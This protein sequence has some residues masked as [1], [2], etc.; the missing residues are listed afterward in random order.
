MLTKTTQFKNI[1]I[2]H[3]STVLAEYYTGSEYV[4]LDVKAPKLS[5]TEQGNEQP[6]GQTLQTFSLENL[7]PEIKSFPVVDDSIYKDLDSFKNYWSALPDN[8]V[9]PAL[10]VVSNSMDKFKKTWEIYSWYQGK[11]GQSIKERGGFF[12]SNKDT[13]GDYMFRLFLSKPN[14]NDN[15]AILYMLTNLGLT[16]TFKQKAVTAIKQGKFKKGIG[17]IFR[18]DI[19]TEDKKLLKAL[20]YSTA[21]DW[22]E[23]QSIFKV[24]TKGDSPDLALA[25]EVLSSDQYHEF[26]RQSALEALL[27]KDKTISSEDIKP[28]IINPETRRSAIRIIKSRLDKYHSRGEITK[29]EMITVISPLMPVFEDLVQLVDDFDIKDLQIITDAIDSASLQKVNQ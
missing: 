12:E 17:I 4:W 27:D 3:E 8:Q 18:G 5:F 28:F 11:L 9:I 7:F 23:N 2:I 22:T 10:L 20:F 6:A 15:T 29:E 13:L 26:V 21:H 24:L 1:P 25:R 19:S 14:Q 16:D